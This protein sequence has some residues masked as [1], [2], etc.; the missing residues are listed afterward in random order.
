MKIKKEL[1]EKINQQIKDLSKQ[2]ISNETLKNQIIEIDKAKCFI[3]TESTNKLLDKQIDE[4]N[5]QIELNKNQNGN[6]HD[7]MLF[8]AEI[9]NTIKTNLNKDINYLIKKEEKNTKKAIKLVENLMLKIKKYNE[10]VEQK[11]ERYTLRIGN[12]IDDGGWYQ[13]KSLKNK[14]YEAKKWMEDN[15]EKK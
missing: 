11:K 3:E 1:L 14:L 15:N 2:V 13:P 6:I 4:L 5:K 8:L 7:E 12:R 9:A 10:I